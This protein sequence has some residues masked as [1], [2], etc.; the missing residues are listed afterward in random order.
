[1][2]EKGSEFEG[3]SVEEAIEVALEELGLDRAEVH[4]E[5]LEEEQKGF[6]GIGGR[7]AR[8]RV[9]PIGD[10]TVSRAEPQGEAE[11]AA[12]VELETTPREAGAV[13]EEPPSIE[14]EYPEEKRPPSLKPM[15][16]VE[17][18]LEMMGIE[19]EVEQ[20]DREESVVVDIWG[21]DVAIV[22][23]K[24]GSTLDALQYLVNVACRRTGEVDRRIVVDAESYRKRRKARL[25]KY[26]DRM[27]EKAVSE[28]KRVR[29]DPMNASERRIVH[30]ALRDK[31]GVATESEGEEPE[32]YV[33]ISP[34]E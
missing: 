4:V 32:R 22:I 31:S 28:R 21:E 17:D 26:A 25:E 3:K 24:G 11:P 13:R 12:A 8:V 19:A 10:Y 2:P 23:G 15:R 7:R 27:A 1:M 29:L 14:E 33:V 16:M 6:L 20:K 18:I 34:R 9:E 30:M 5:V